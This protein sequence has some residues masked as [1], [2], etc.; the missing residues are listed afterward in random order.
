M[1]RA[2]PSQINVL[3][4]IVRHSLY[5]GIWVLPLCHC[6]ACCRYTLLFAVAT[7]VASSLSGELRVMAFA[8]VGGDG[9]LRFRKWLVRA[10]VIGWRQ[11]GSWLYP[12]SVY[13]TMPA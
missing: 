5:N 2:Y 6:P 1:L 4:P 9:H 13:P 10:L 7:K 11:L 3:P 12:L 8:R